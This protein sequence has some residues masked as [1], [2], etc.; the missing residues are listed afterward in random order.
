MCYFS[1]LNL[2]KKVNFKIYIH[3]KEDKLIEYV[4]CDVFV[5]LVGDV[6][7]QNLYSQISYL[8]SIE[9]TPNYCLFQESYYLYELQK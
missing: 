7:F 8:I 3:R 6:I 4:L 1:P 2:P 9:D 5:N